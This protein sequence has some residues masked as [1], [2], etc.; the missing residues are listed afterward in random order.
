MPDAPLSDAYHNLEARFRRIAL[1][2]E[3][4]AV[5]H[6]DYAAV[7][8]TGGAEARS[9]QL[10]ELKAISH[11]LL[12][13]AETSDLIAAAKQNITNLDAWQAAN[14]REIERLHRRSSALDE[15]FVTKQSRAVS[16]CE[17]AWRR[18]RAESD[19]SIVAKPL[20]ELTE[21]VRE[22]ATRIGEVFGLDPYDALLDSY[23][24]GGRAANI[25]PVL[26]DLAAYL[27]GFLEDVLEYQASRGPAIMPEGPFPEET[28]RA[29]GI[30]FMGVLGFDFERGRLDVS[31]HPFCGGVPDDV[32]ITTRYDENDFTSAL[33]GVLHET[34]HALYEQ[35]LPQEW[36]LQPVG[37]ALGMSIHESQSLL[38]EMQV[39]RSP[40]FIS[41]ALPII[42]ETFGG[43]GPA[44]EP[45]NIL[46]L[47]HK[48][49]RSY[50]R[51]DADE[52][53]YPL[54]VILR[55]RLE[56]DIIAGKLATNDLPE[57]WNAAFKE[58]I[59]IDVP[60]DAQ[61]CLQD[62][63]WYDGDL[64]Y[65]P[66]YTL[67]AM[68]AAQLYQAACAAH[69]DIP[70]SITRGDFSVLLTWLRD[71]IHGNGRLLSGAELLTRATGR[72]LEAAPFKSHLK[73]RYLPD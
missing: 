18:A 42:R 10:A 53:T 65:F 14:L 38:M 67:G 24:P 9:E 72:P 17:Q 66:T 34:G 35:G 40:Q 12:V 62:L 73:A 64:G 20:E 7:M 41:F 19:F 61:G 49:E 30:R 39:C 60:D 51:V 3:A 50:I 6:W 13:G 4:E 21:L 27:P 1:L 69:P 48:V 28:Q 46:K 15:A 68:T 58:L 16:T 63:H 22:E 45:D 31:H 11:G 36:R 37:S 25:D 33:M 43:S 26:D 71:N 47:Y 54:H 44:W 23:E 5:L 52:V 59:G 57:A 8:P 55:Y 29:L 32:R 56:K 2:G 70:A